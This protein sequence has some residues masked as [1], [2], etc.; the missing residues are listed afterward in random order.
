MSKGPLHKTR[1]EWTAI[2]K[3]LIQGR[4]SNAHIEGAGVD[5]EYATN[6]LVL[7]MQSE[8]AP[9]ISKRAQR[10]IRAHLL[11]DRRRWASDPSK[12]TDH[13]FGGE[14]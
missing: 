7:W 2:A 4:A 3:R 13:N 9:R 14:A 11:E 10:A 6:R 12:S 1:K 5:I 8:D